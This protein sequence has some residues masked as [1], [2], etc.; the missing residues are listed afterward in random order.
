MNASLLR[1]SRINPKLLA[2]TKMYGQ[3]DCNRVTIVPPG[4]KCAT[5]EV[6][7]K[8]S[9]CASLRV[10]ALFTDPSLQHFRCCEVFAQKT[11]SKRTSGTINFLPP[12]TSIPSTTSKSASLRKEKDLMNLSR[13]EKPHHPHAQNADD[14]LAALNEIHEVLE[15]PEKKMK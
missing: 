6:T 4:W 3:F 13:G 2:H 1:N 11:L 5:H 8:I 14:T 12:I 9:T 10:Q 15:T 7:V